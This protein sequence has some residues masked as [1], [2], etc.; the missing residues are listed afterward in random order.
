LKVVSWNLLRQIGATVE[1]VATLIKEQRPDLLLLQEATRELEALPSFVGGHFHRVPLPDRIHGL[2]VWSPCAFPEPQAVPLPESRM[3]GRVP[4]RVAPGWTSW[5]K[6]L[7]R[8]LP[9]WSQP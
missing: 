7:P 1:D 3:P 5:P 8:P 9:G 4:R 2:A 6:P